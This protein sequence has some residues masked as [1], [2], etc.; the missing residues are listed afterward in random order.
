MAYQ[1][2]DTHRNQIRLLHIQPGRFEET[3]RC[4]VST[5]SLDDKP[6]YEALS[7]VWGTLN[8]TVPI[9]FEN[10]PVEV[11]RNLD[12]ALRHIRY[13]DRERVIWND[14]LCINQPDIPERN[15]QV[16]RMNVL[17]SKASRVVIFLG[18]EGEDGGIATEFFQEM[19]RN[20]DLHLDPS[21]SPHVE[22]YGLSWGDSGLTKAIARFFSRPWWQRV[23]T[24]QEFILAEDIVFQI[25]NRS[26]PG[27]LMLTFDRV[28]AKHSLG[29]CYQSFRSL[30]DV[31]EKSFSTMAFGLEN[32][33]D[34][35]ALH[36]NRSTV[37]FADIL[38]RYKNRE[39]Y[40]PRDKIYGMLGLASEEIVS[41]IKPD[42][43]TPASQVYENA[44][45]T[46]MRKYGNM[47]I[48]SHIIDGPSRM[49][50]LPS[51]VPD[52]S[53]KV[54]PILYNS[55]IIRTGTMANFNA[56]G[57]RPLQ[58]ENP[59]PGVCATPSILIDTIQAIGEQNKSGQA[60]PASWP[61][62]AKA[63]GNAPYMGSH[64]SRWVAFLQTVCGGT[65]L[66]D[67]RN[68]RRCPDNKLDVEMMSDW[69]AHKSNGL[70]VKSKD[71]A[72]AV[73]CAVKGR[74]VFLSRNGYIGLAPASAKEGDIVAVF[75]GAKVP[76]ILRE[77]LETEDHEM[78]GVSQRSHYRVVGDGYV[79]GIMDGE[80]FRDNSMGSK[81]RD[82]ILI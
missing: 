42:Y 80:A 54:D 33:Q 47:D 64:S 16:A 59:A 50:N 22:I 66:Y 5:V 17:Y 2:L 8:D 79:H 43:T 45:L 81:V 70:D 26:L 20:P 48:M 53:A 71:Y 72:N 76:F 35:P 46:I 30:F 82:I 78:Q 67:G 37:P 75:P 24:V 7:Y 18:E 52:W 21:K 13:P 68:F 4:T 63:F 39:C 61:V 73:G 74:R 3:P 29:C 27:S 55:Y 23:W 49:P 51:W 31:D 6:V 12:R 56:S 14:A 41:L 15:A 57:S 28:F 19:S 58:I 65:P 38:L 1:P 60:V 9:I 44:A 34:F 10:K 62:V 40:D 69:L 11:T 77:A 25:G 36:K 32:L